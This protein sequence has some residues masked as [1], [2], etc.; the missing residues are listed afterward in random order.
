MWLG[1]QNVKGGAGPDAST[2]AKVDLDVDWVQF[3]TPRG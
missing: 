3:A 1:M 2:P